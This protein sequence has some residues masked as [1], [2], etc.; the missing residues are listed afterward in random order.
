MYILTVSNYFII[1]NQSTK[2]L[3]QNQ[4]LVS[5]LDDRLSKSTKLIWHH[6]QNTSDSL[7]QRNI[8]FTYFHLDCECLFAIMN[9]INLQLFGKHGCGQWSSCVNEHAISLYLHRCY[10]HFG[11]ISVLNISQQTKQW[12]YYAAH[13]IAKHFPVNCIRSNLTLKKLL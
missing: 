1:T 7:Y 11:I 2:S 9:I 5:L 6:I 8:C 3:D 13:I 12:V 10:E 4:Y